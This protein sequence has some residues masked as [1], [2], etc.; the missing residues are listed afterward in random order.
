MKSNFENL[1]GIV[2]KLTLLRI[3][4]SCSVYQTHHLQT[5]C[6]QKLS[7]KIVHKKCLETMST[8]IV[9]Q[10]FQQKVVTKSPQQVVT[11]SIHKK[12]LQKVSRNNVHKRYPHIFFSQKVVTKSVH[13]KCP[14][15]R[16]Q[17]VQNGKKRHETSVHTDISQH[18]LQIQ[19]VKF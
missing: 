1:R 17:A 7:T 14:K 15:K 4:N 5:D 9:H 16:K 10:K 12:C 19:Y 3:F 13:N 18:P 8:K 2:E 11:K 6:P